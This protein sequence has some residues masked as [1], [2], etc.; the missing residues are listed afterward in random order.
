MYLNDTI[1]FYVIISLLKQKNYYDLK[2]Q[3][4]FK[5]AISSLTKVQ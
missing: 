5:Y 3:C 4:I 2:I 1:L